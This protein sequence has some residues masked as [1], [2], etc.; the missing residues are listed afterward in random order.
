MYIFGL[1]GAWGMGGMVGVGLWNEDQINLC[2]SVSAGL[3][4]FG[5][6]IEDHVIMCV[7][8][9]ECGCGC[10]GMIKQICVCVGVWCLGE[11][12]D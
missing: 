11:G 9:Y 7:A 10:G 2:A 1:L 6:S 3:V 5:V 8:G 4:E 12:A